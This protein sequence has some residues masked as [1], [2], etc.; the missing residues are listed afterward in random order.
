MAHYKIKKRAVRKQSLTILQRLAFGL[1][2]FVL[3]L[4]PV[5]FGS[6][7]VWAYSLFSMAAF[8]AT[9]LLI[10]QDM[11]LSLKAKDHTPPS[12]WRTPADLW[13][14]LFAA[15]F[16]LQL[17]PLPESVVEILSPIWPKSAIKCRL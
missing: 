14:L 5:F 3:I 15:V 17:L 9:G 11:L 2:L 4:S 12:P 1:L 6:V 8:T 7:H 10:I 16:A 13:I